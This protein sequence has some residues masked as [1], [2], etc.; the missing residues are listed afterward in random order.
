[1]P[2]A[3]HVYETF[4]RT[5]PERLWQA[6]T[7]PGLTRR[8]FFDCGFDGTVAKGEDYRYVAADGSVAV[9]GTITEAEPYRR[10]QMTF[11]VGF[12]SAAAEEHP[13]QVTWEIAPLGDVCR[14]TLV[15][16]DLF[17]APRT[18]EVTTGGWERLMSSLK[19]LLETG[20]PL[21]A[22]PLAEGEEAPGLDHDLHRA[23]AIDA[24]NAT[25][26]L[27]ART[28]RMAEDDERMVDTAHAAAY[29]WAKVGTAVNDARADHLCARTYAY[30]GRA[31]PAL[32]HARRCLALVEANGMTDFDLAYAHEAMARAFALDGQPDEARRHL[33][34]ARAVPIADSEDREIF[35][36]DVADGPWY[37]LA[38]ER[39]SGA[40]GGGLRS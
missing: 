26:A 28:D 40:P 20:E 36:G 8:Y 34:A 14:L 4:I 38:G 3:R 16:G 6:L 39:P 19:T 27:L 33:A 13:S 15:H 21:P 35:E 1:V 23:L 25:F 10:L 29:H 12:D 32:H 5:S 2:P 18:Y 31:E 7:D 22:I 11:H 37:G 9:D 17:G 24:N 30:V